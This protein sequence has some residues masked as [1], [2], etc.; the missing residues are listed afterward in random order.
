MN[1]NENAGLILFAL[2]FCRIS[3]C[4]AFVLLQ[5]CSKNFSFAGP[6]DLFFCNHFEL[7]YKNELKFTKFGDK[8]IKCIC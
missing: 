4:F 7:V 3:T 2:R 5:K 8:Y 6:P 1:S